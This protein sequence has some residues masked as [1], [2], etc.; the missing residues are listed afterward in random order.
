MKLMKIVEVLL[1]VGVMCNFE[2]GVILFVMVVCFFGYIEKV[3]CFIK[4]KVVFNVID[5]NDK[6][7]L[8]VV[9]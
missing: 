4:D 3:K 8:I 5:N 6:I 1:K 2:V 7:L 9:C